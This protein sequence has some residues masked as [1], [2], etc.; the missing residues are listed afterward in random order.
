MKTW[1]NGKVTYTRENRMVRVYRHRDKK[2]GLTVCDFNDIWLH[3]T[4]TSQPCYYCGNHK[5]IGADRLDNNKGHTKDN[6]VPCCKQCNMIKNNFFTSEEFKM[7]VSFCQ[8]KN[9][10]SHLFKTSL[11]S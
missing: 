10:A 5:E 6:I 8:D 11:L 2:K 1:T 4:I 9:I 7:I 3:D